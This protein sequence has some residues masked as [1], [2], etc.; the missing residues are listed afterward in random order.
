MAVL[1]GRFIERELIKTKIAHRIDVYYS[2]TELIDMLK[3][4]NRAPDILFLAVKMTKPDGMTIS[5]EFTKRYCRTLIIF[6]SAYPDALEETLISEPFGCILKR[7][8]DMEIPYFMEKALRRLFVFS[9]KNLRIVSRGMKLE[10]PERKIRYFMCH[11]KTVIIYTDDDRRIVIRD[12]LKRLSGELNEEEFILINRGVLVNMRF[13]D[14]VY[15]RKV[16]MKC[17]TVFLCSE[18]RWAMIKN[19]CPFFSVTEKRD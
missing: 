6:V 5:C 2:G 8:I 9:G 3:K 16:Y 1:T 17:G 14:K 13:V 11:D 15:R 19:I 7:N 18:G 4:D 10:I 12:T